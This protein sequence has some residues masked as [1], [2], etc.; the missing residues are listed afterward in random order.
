EAIGS[1]A[2]GWNLSRAQISFGGLKDRHARTEQAITIRGGPERDFDGSVFRA[3]FLGRSRDPITRASFTGNR[4]EITVRDL[5][6]IPDLGAERRKLSRRASGRVR[7]RLRAPRAEP[8]DSLPLR[9][10]ELDLE[11][12]AGGRDPETPGRLRG[13]LRRRDARLLPRARRRRP[14]PAGRA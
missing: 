5:A 1:L 2:K 9:L 11:P 10:P 3:E 14:R 12:H 6:E 7:L 8:P 13:R 4:F